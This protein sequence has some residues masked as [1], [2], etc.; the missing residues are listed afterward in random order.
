VA[1]RQAGIADNVCGQ[2]RRQ[3]ALLTGHGNFP[4]LLQRIVERTEQ[5]GNQR[6]PGMGVTT[7]SSGFAKID[8]LTAAFNAIACWR[9]TRHRYSRA[10]F[11][12]TRRYWLWRDAEGVEQPFAIPQHDHGGVVVAPCLTLRRIG[13][14]H[15]H[16]A[17][18]ERDVR[19]EGP[20]CIDTRLVANTRRRIRPGMRVAAPQGCT[21]AVVS[22]AVMRKS[23]STV[24]RRLNGSGSRAF[25]RASSST[26]SART[27]C[28]RCLLSAS[29][30]ARYLITIAL[31]VR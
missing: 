11:G 5:L 2:D 4:A 21:A 31:Y 19:A 18:D 22:S 12:L 17:I 25:Q 13:L 16:F 7:A 9:R 26:T 14:T 6:Q 29:F 28:S 1:L 15:Q 24:N 8:P 23:W 10:Y 30:C 27:F 3:F 20:H